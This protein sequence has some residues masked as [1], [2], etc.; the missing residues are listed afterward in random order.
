MAVGDGEDGLRQRDEI[1][2]FQ[3]ER[4]D[5]IGAMA[6]EPGAEEHQLRLDAVGEAIQFI[7]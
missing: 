5:R 3:T 4:T 2:G 1:F 6:V 7:R